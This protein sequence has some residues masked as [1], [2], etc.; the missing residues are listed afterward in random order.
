MWCEF[1]ANTIVCAAGGGWILVSDGFEQ[2]QP[3]F[4]HLA[5]CC[6]ATTLCMSNTLAL[7]FDKIYFSRTNNTIATG[8]GFFDSEFEKVASSDTYEL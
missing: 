8:S 4:F 2:S 7:A 6:C 5:L 1:D 3:T